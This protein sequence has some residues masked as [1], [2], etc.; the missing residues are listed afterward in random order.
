MKRHLVTIIFGLVIGLATEWAT[1][2]QASQYSSKAGLIAGRSVTS[3]SIVVERTNHDLSSKRALV[4]APKVQRTETPSLLASGYD[5]KK[6]FRG[7]R[8][9]EIE[10]APL[11]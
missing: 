5:S 4:A 10:I 2:A 7:E 9:M 8:R 1:A 11:K 6:A 3:K